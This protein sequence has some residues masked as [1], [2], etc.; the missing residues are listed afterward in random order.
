VKGSFI[1]Y[2]LSDFRKVHFIA[3]GGIGM[4]ALARILIGRGMDVRGSDE[5]ASHITENLALRGAVI[6]IGHKKEQIGDAELVVVSSAIKYKNE[7]LDEA[8][9]LG[10]PIWHRSELLKA[11]MNEK[12]SI[13]VTG[14]HGKT[15][16]SSMLTALLIHAQ[17]DPAAILGGE[18]SLIEGNSCWGEGAFLVAEVD[19]SDGSFLNLNS[20][21]VIITNIEA[22]HLDHYGDL[23]KI[24]DAFV[25]Y[26]NQIPV[27]GMAI[28]GI[29][30]PSVRKIIPRLTCKIRTFG[31]S[32]DADIQAREVECYH[33]GSESKLYSEGSFLGLIRLAV[34]GEYNVMNAFAAAAMA[35]EIGLSIQEIQD[36]L[37]RF[38]SSKRRYELIG[39][40]RGITIIED[41]AHHPTEVKA[42]LAAARTESCKRVVIV[43]QPHLYSRTRN[44]KDEFGQAFVQADFVVMTDVFASREK[45]PEQGISGATLV[46]TI[47]QWDP[48]RQV[49]Y[50]PDK[51][52][53]VKDLIP[54]L[55]M[56][57]LVLFVGAG[58]I[59]QFGV[60]LYQALAAQAEIE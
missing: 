45:K 32:T 27:N 23:S 6:Y 5:I 55:Q 59:N 34:P 21:Y 22:D 52:D 37:M 54:L 42:L 15:T 1:L 57:D 48:T 50:I 19:E 2:N 4:S 60:E 3:I 25:T 56:G 14:A 24:E 58:D 29:D 9:R 11:L 17:K 39:A 33:G 53:I 46:E 12:I 30:S 13:A 44:F 41:Y 35:L 10:I 38:Q 43:F 7:E 47:A 18:L 16:T 31:F 8:K 51:N 40:Q 36:G 28:L 49:I 26:L 20:Q